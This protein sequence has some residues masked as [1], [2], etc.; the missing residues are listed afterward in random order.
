MKI[1][2]GYEFLTQDRPSSEVMSILGKLPIRWGRMDKLSRLV[3][4]EVGQALKRDGH[5]DQ[6]GSRLP[7]SGT[8]GLVAGTR[9]GS[10]Q[11]DLA[12]CESLKPGPG[13]ASP[14]LFSYTLANISLAETAAHYGLTGPVY[15]LFSEQPYEDALWEAKRWLATVDYPLQIVTGEVDIVPE[16]S[17]PL[18]SQDKK[19]YRTSARFT[20]I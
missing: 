8:V 20:V 2:S 11:T 10:L 14:A 3:L 12:Y 9:R 17:P 15:N 6:Q 4:F 18:I 7:S 19:K 13:Q 16:I 5:L 1:T